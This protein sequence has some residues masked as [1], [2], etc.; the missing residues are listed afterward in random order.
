[1]HNG[2]V[3]RKSS[4]FTLVELAVVIMIIGILITISVFAWSS[5]RRT[6]ATN[7]LKSDL[8]Q[9][10]AQLKND[11]NW[12]NTYPTTQNETNGNKGLPKSKGTTYDYT[13][14]AGLNRYCLM[15]TSDRAGIPTFF[16][17]SQ[18]TT[19]QQGTCTGWNPDPDPD[20]GPGPGPEPDPVIADGSYIQTVTSANC[21]TSRI[22]A[23]DARD[24]RTYWVQK[25]ADDK[26]WMLTNLAYAGGG[27]NTYSDVKTL[28]TGSEVFTAPRYY[29][30]TGANPTTE[31]TAPSTATT[32]TGQYGYLYNWCGAMGGQATAACA[33]ATTPAPN[34]SISVCPAGWRLPTGNT[35]GDFQALNAAVNGG[36]TNTDAGLRTVWLGQRSGGWTTAGYYD[37]GTQG[38]YWSS[39]QQASEYAYRLRFRNNSAN[40]SGTQGR[41]YKDEGHAVRCIAI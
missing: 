24:G 6:T 19:P 7:V 40:F 4:G 3:S 14:N 2:Y 39:N 1:M 37:Q 26:C 20:P 21:P 33:N 8:S 12:K 23:V 32:G 34:P 10:A 41:N 31:P 27:T 36:L 38:L 9:A 29:I 30:P 17:T 18:N 11:L 28:T 16:I 13:Y 15:A 35:G 25:L 5:W 22:R